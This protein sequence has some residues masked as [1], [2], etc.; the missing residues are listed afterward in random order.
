V[1]SEHSYGV[2]PLRMQDGQ[3]EVLLVHHLAGHWGFPKGHK[4]EGETPRQTAE[5][6]LFEETGLNIVRIFSPQPLM[7]SY[8]YQREGHSVD[9]EV[10]YFVAEVEGT[11]SAQAEEL[12][13]V[14]WYSWQPAEQ[15]LTYQE[16]RT[17][18]ER[19]ATLLPKT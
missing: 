6:E 14:C 11:I 8:T 13:E 7:E 16:G 4:E 2:I 18:L 17:L 10:H 12:H 9:K 3:W 15:T 5:R 19:A 1:T